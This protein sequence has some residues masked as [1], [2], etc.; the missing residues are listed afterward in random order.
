MSRVPQCLD[1]LLTYVGLVVSLTHWPRSTPQKRC[2]TASGIHFCWRLSK[3]QGLVRLEGLGKF[4]KR[5][6]LIETRTLDFP[7]CSLAPQ[8]CTLPRA[9]D[10]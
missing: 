9:P 5:N 1:N 6:D 3:P 7:A 2:F 4:N 10:E 8:P